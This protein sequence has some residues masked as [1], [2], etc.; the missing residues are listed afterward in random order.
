VYK[1]R[2]NSKIIPNAKIIPPSNNTDLIL[3]TIPNNN[4]KEKDLSSFNNMVLHHH[5]HT[6]RS[7]ST[8]NQKSRIPCILIG[9]QSLLKQNFLAL[10]KLHSL[11]LVIHNHQL[12]LC[13][14]ESYHDL[15]TFFKSTEKKFF[16]VIYCYEHDTHKQ[17]LYEYWHPLIEKFVNSNMLRP[18][19]C[20]ISL[21][22]VDHDSKIVFG[23]LGADVVVDSDPNCEDGCL[24]AFQELTEVIAA[25][26]WIHKHS[27]SA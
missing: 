24:G 26:H 27:S 8:T 22:G 25:K 18:V 2:G 21:N 23:R 3:D 5:Q 13:S 6:T 14:I 17:Q 12:Q 4:N 19:I 16:I 7:T 10:A 20:C 11:D 1:I 9:E 15:E